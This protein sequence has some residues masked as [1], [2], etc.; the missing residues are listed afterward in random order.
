M[1]KMDTRFDVI[2]IGGGMVGATL[3]RALAP[4]RLRIA[5]I[6][7]QPPQAVHA[8]TLF[9]LRVSAITRASQRIFEALDVWQGMVARRVSPFREMH[10]WEQA[11]KEI[12]FD[13]AE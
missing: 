4:T 13:S 12:H 2:I 6:E 5:L 11:G 7:P 1:V 8:D 10:V 9:D 3:A